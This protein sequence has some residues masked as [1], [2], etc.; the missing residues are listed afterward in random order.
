MMTSTDSLDTLVAS[1]RT[2]V[3]S[4]R[5][6]TAAD[7][8]ELES[9]LREQIADLEV[10][11]LSSDE[12]FLIAV[13]RLGEVNEL[14]AEYAREHGERVWKQLTLT[15]SEGEGRRPFL[16]ML[17]L[18]VVAVVAI[19]VPRLVAGFPESSPEWFFRNLGFFVLPVLAGYFAVVAGVSRVRIA[20][21]AALVA[22]LC[23]VV[24]LY[25]FAAGG[26]TSTLV[27]IHLPFLLWF[28]VAATYIG[29]LGSSARRMDFIRFVG[30]WA[31]YY[32]L[33]ALGGAVLLALTFVVFGLILPT[34]AFDQ[35]LFWVMP[36][37][38][39]AAV[40]VAAWLVE[41]KKSI[42]E[43]IAPVLTAIFTPLFA[44]MLFVAA[45]GYVALGIG[46]DF[47]RSLLTAF[48]ILLLVVVALVVYG[49]SARDASKP[50]GVMDAIRLVAVVAAVIVDVL[51]LVSLLTRVG[52]LGFTANRVAAL[53]LNLIL[54]ANLIGTIWYSVGVFA[55]RSRIAQLE[56]WQTAFL[57]VLGVWLLVVVLVLPPVF[58]FA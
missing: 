2:A 8:D 34:T 31:I 23:I 21:T 38:A 4:H 41:S 17:V 56:T 26:D 50:G 29:S 43:N 35:L 53:G 20:V 58:A 42:V 10:T 14:T 5:A 37:G 9:H 40:I 16:V 54:L 1:W 57:P 48:D 24:N 51:V 47:D 6:V 27:G 22:A 7:A 11:G 30:E 33:I 45:V 49:I 55:K 46:S 39:A 12:A 52:E 32:V 25:P 3:L 18:A 28:A 13:K 19:Q 15:V 44:V 36:S